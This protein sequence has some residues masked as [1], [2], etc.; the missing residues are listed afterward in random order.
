MS[1]QPREPQF[2]FSQFDMVESFLPLPHESP[3]PDMLSHSPGGHL[4]SFAFADGSFDASLSNP[5]NFS[6]DEFIDD[7][8]NLPVDARAS[9]A[10]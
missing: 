3:A 7:S 5:L 9:G 2:D 1:V 4:D 10:A 6:F 8:A